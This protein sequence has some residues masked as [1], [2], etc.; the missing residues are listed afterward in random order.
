[1]QMKAFNNNN[2]D[3]LGK[4]ATTHCNDSNS[5]MYLNVPNSSQ[6][7]A[8]RQSS[9]PQQQPDSTSPSG[10]SYSETPVNALTPDMSLVTFDQQLMAETHSAAVENCFYEPE[11]VLLA[12]QRSFSVPDLEEIPFIDLEM[13]EEV[14]VR[15]RSQRL[16][17]TSAPCAQIDSFED[18]KSMQNANNLR[19]SSF[20]MKVVNHVGTMVVEEA[21]GG[22]K[23]TVTRLGEVAVSVCT[24]KNALLP[25]LAA[26]GI[27]NSMCQWWRWVKETTLRKK[28]MSP[29]TMKSYREHRRD[30]KERKATKTLAIVVGKV[31][32]Q[33]LLL[34]SSF[35]VEAFQEFHFDSSLEKT[36]TEVDF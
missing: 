36:R 23:E 16:R 12:P 21:A 15:N 34:E 2:A 25:N 6:A 22:P 19:N 13:D 28:P 3:T 9:S 18:N 14:F 33:T 31:D 10:E 26:G 1:M 4:N 20:K 17:Y 5:V 24:S 32:I 29:T 7:R 30:R 8:K 27:R 35:S 11:I